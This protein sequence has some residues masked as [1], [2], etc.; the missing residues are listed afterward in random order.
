MSEEEVERLRY[1]LSRSGPIQEALDQCLRLLDHTSI[2]GDVSYIPKRDLPPRKEAGLDKL[3]ACICLPPTRYT[4]TT[5]RHTENTVLGMARPFLKLPPP[6]PLS[7]V[8]RPDAPPLGPPALGRGSQQP[9][10]CGQCR[11]RSRLSIP[12]G[13]EATSARSFTC[14]GRRSTRRKKV[15][16]KV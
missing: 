12:T 5:P 11:C 1:S 4:Y 10:L 7:L 16:L 9:V 14:A 2:A 8:C 15:R 6:P 13:S 3:S